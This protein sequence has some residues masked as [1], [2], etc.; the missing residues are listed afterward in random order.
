MAK[1]PAQ[2]Q[3]K[4]SLPGLPL[5]FVANV[6]LEILKVLVPATARVGLND[7]GIITE[8][9]SLLENYVI[10]GYSRPVDPVKPDEDLSA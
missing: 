3:I 6:R 9:A 4:P 5:E 1:S 8:K 10:H 2:H 7:P